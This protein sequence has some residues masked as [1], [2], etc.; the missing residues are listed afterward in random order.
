MAQFEEK[1]TFFE[2]M[3]SF[4]SNSVK[5]FPYNRQASFSCILHILMRKTRYVAQF[6][7]KNTFFDINDFFCLFLLKCFKSAEKLS[8]AVYASI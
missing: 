6:V 7:E 3:T 8:V 1:N 4:W 2:K 5:K